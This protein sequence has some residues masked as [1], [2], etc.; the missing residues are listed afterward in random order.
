MQQEHLSV[1]ASIADVASVLDKP[2]GKA[3]AAVLPQGT[4]LHL[5]H[6]SMSVAAPPQYAD[7][8]WTVCLPYICPR[9]AMQD[10]TVQ[11]AMTEQQHAYDMV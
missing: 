1:V 6:A 11:H 7:Q 3:P 8:G 4:S 10:A 9:P 2:L 5:L